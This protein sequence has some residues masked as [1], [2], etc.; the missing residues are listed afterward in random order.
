MLHPEELSPVGFGCYRITNTPAHRQA[1]AHAVKEGCNLFDTASTYTQGN[2]EKMAGELAQAFPQK[3][4][5]IIS[6][7]GYITPDL[8]KNNTRFKKKLLLADPLYA[9]GTPHSIHPDFLRLQLKRSLLR[10]NRRCLDAFLIHNP[11]K[12]YLPSVTTD[13]KNSSLRQ[14]FAFLEEMV[15]KGKIRYY[16]ISS[17]TLPLPEA[18]NPLPPFAQ[19]WRI[20]TETSPDPAFRLLQFPFN[21]GETAAAISHGKSSLLQQA[22]E[23]HII[24]LSN[25][26][27]NIYRHDGLIRLGAEF[28]DTSDTAA[29]EKK[30]MQ[31]LEAIHRQLQ[32]LGIT[33]DFPVVAA[34]KEYWNK[35]SDP[36]AVAALFTHQFFVF[37]RQLFGGR[38]PATVTQLMQEV[39]DSSNRHTRYNMAQRSRQ[40]IADLIAQGRINAT[41]LYPIAATACRH[42]L[43]TGI[44]HVLLGMRSV[45]YVD[46]VKTLFHRPIHANR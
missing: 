32:L 26:P 17:N 20:A 23:Q 46:Q 37:I 21:F 11:E 25:R 4:L 36:Q 34:V 16:G 8:F 44:D 6:K 2:A 27:L 3:K 1:L 18:D 13:E 33:E 41:D 9:A 24:T 29:D 42:Y 10:L 38:I 15:H 43:N 39:F 7:A 12:C 35:L 28:N 5:F 19:L 30:V 14:A 31:L 40:F 22:R 45:Q